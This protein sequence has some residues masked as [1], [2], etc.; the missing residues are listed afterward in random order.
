MNSNGRASHRCNLSS[1]PQIPSF[2]PSKCR[3]W[4]LKGTPRPISQSPIQRHHHVHK[5]TPKPISQ[6]PIRC[7]KSPSTQH[8]PHQ[9]GDHPTSPNLGLQGAPQ[10]REW[11]QASHAA[12]TAHK[13]FQS[14]FRPPCLSDA[15]LRFFT[16]FRRSS[17]FHN[18]QSI[19]FS[20]SPVP[21]LYFTQLSCLTTGPSLHPHGPSDVPR[22]LQ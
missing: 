18:S 3:P 11:C 12:I 7:S 16:S 21:P 2:H 9:T 4:V 19:S 10:L 22:A 14:P 20:A 5:G 13:S 1:E 6:P 17:S 15:A 8:T